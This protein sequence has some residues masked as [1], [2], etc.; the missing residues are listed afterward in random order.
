MKKQFSFSVLLLAA[1][2][3][4]VSS[5]A[6]EDNVGAATYIVDDGEWM[7]KDSDKDKTILPGDNFYMYCNGGY[8]EST[9]L[10]KQLQTGF[11]VGEVSAALS[12]RLSQLPQRSLGYMEAHLAAMMPEDS[13]GAEFLETQ[14]RPLFSA[15]SKEDA[16]R[17]TGQMA[18]HGVYCGFKLEPLNL[19]G[20]AC[21]AL[22]PEQ[23]LLL[24]VT[25]KSFIDRLELLK[26]AKFFESLRPVS[27]KRDGHRAFDGKAWP[28]LMAWC[29]G[30]GVNPDDVLIPHDYHEISTEMTDSVKASIAQMEA[31]FE[32][33]QEMSLAEYQQEM[34]STITTDLA[35][36]N[37]KNFDEAMKE[38][39]ET[40]EIAP[41]FNTEMTLEQ[42]MNSI[43][44][45]ECSYEQSY[46]YVQRFDLTKATERTNAICQG[47]KETFTNRIRRC[48]WMSE[49]SKA[50]C[51][52]KLNNM[53]FCIG[54]PSQ[55]YEEGLPDLS[56]GKSLIEDIVNIRK[57]QT[58]MSCRMAGK[59]IDKDLAFNIV[60]SHGISL[61]MLNAIY[62]PSFN[63]M[64]ILPVFMQ[65]PLY[66]DYANEAYNYATAVV[67]AHE[68]THGFDSDGAKFNKYGTLGHIM[69]SEADIK[70]FNERA[71]TVA[72]SYSQLEVVPELLPGLFND[73]EYTQTENIADLGGFE[74]VFETYTNRLKQQG[75]E[76]KELTRQQQRL[77]EAYAHLW[78]E[79][80]SILYA[81][82][83]T[84]G[85]GDNLMGKDNHSLAKERIN[86]VVMN[87]DA[88]YELFDVQPGQNLYRAPEERAHV[89]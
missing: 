52:D 12:Q 35:F 66:Y 89:W 78:Q 31:N 49:A 58:E 46:E 28:M 3:S 48:T 56:E 27:G 38:L 7:V 16:W 30:M 10:G 74:M 32:R 77:Y 43:Y 37:E 54:A 79:K 14:T 59:Q 70:A 19:E 11:I 69:A 9:V 68:I 88:W 29:E 75:F 24:S 83:R 45:T 73:G 5:C 21:F 41:L 1:M 25:R 86:G 81:L 85:V 57:A 60:L 8:W 50:N 18:R 34:L 39:S 82:I 36:L 55:W 61:T 47:L 23:P 20:R 71:K 51:I 33:M 62:V 65:E 64:F 4:L 44:S 2:A 13:T 15:V 80:Y 63:A 72:D 53:Q 76:G 87:T 22:L 17:A 40:P 6:R 67:Y 42:A 84:T 26:D